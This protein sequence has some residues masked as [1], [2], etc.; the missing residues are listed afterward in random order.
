MLLTR[1][2]GIHIVEE[3]PASGSQRS[4][5]K[6]ICAYDGSST[7]RFCEGLGVV[8]VQ[9]LEPRLDGVRDLADLIDVPL[10]NM[11]HAVSHVEMAD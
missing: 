9:L 5:F 2:E 6:S 11:Q 4:C 10:Q 3:E 7:H 1:P 8:A